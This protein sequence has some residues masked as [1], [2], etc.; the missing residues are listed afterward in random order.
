MKKR[1]LLLISCLALLMVMGIAGTSSANFTYKIDDST[2]G[3]NTYWGGRVTNGYEDRDVIGGKAYWID[4]MTV[5][6]NARGAG[7]NIKTNMADKYY[8]RDLL[9]ANVRIGDLF[10]S[11]DG[12]NPIGTGPHYEED[13][14]NP[15]DPQSEEW[16]YVIVLDEPS[17]VQ[18]DFYNTHRTAELY[19]VDSRKITYSSNAGHFKFWRK[20]QEI[21]YNPGSQ[22]PLETGF[23]S[24][25]DNS[26]MNEIRILFENPKLETKSILKEIFD[27]PDNQ[28][29]FKYGQTCGNDMIAGNAVPVPPSLLLLGTGLIGMVGFR[30]KSKG[31]QS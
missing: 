3:D 25:V 7:V 16:E 12:W 27:N 31:G 21:F 24:F 15:N 18:K 28:L 29:A 14:Q 8:Y 4:E 30:K 23:F 11:T 9:G 19:R 26:T 22:T 1:R 5:F 6:S 20:D 17:S 10:I 13:Y 2:W